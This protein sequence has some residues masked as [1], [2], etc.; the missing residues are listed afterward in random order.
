M[1]T[2]QEGCG[3]N[4][5]TYSKAEY[6]ELSSKVASLEAELAKLRA[7]LERRESEEKA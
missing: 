4:P 3:P 1:N 7:Q 2:A 5:R 6:D